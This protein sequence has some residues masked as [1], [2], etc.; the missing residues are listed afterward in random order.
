MIS[1]FQVSLRLIISLFLGALIGLER[2]RLKLEAAGFR[3]FS[4]VSLASCFFILL[5]FFLPQINL[6]PS[7][8]LS[9]IVVGIGFIGAG[10]ILKQGPKVF[11][12]TTAAGLWISSAIGAG[13]GIGLL[14]EAIL[15]TFLTV[16]V[17]FGFGKLEE[18]YLK[19]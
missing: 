9:A 6:D 7:R 16:L 18:K 2:E 14:K 4:L 17:L 1:F 5:S 10:V 15:T 8:T 11:G 13:V 12:I 3:T 19:E